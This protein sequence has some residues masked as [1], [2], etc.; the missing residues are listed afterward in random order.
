[1]MFFVGFKIKE[2]SEE[3]GLSFYVYHYIIAISTTLNYFGPILE[4]VTITILFKI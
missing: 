3:D 4:D 2:L 1:M